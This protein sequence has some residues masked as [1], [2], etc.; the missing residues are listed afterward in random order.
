MFLYAFCQIILSPIFHLIRYEKHIPSYVQKTNGYNQQIEC[1]GQT[2]VLH[3][4]QRS[5]GIEIAMCEEKWII[6]NHV[7]V[8]NRL[9]LMECET[10]RSTDQYV[11]NIEKYHDL[12]AI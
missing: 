3:E 7:N 6:S 9:R 12:K 1:E 11:C 10:R 4:Q 2:A 8:I 5:Y